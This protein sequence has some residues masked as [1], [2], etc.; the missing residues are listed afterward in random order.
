MP[1]TVGYHRGTRSSYRSR[2]RY[3]S[4]RVVKRRVTFKRTYFKPRRVF[5]RKIALRNATSSFWKFV[6]SNY[7]KRK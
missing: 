6:N 2:R 5:R 1:R 3:G 4:N 7:R